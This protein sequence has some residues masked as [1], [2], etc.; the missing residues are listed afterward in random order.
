MDAVNIPNLRYKAFSFVKGI[1]KRNGNIECEVP[2][3]YKL[4]FICYVLG[5]IFL[6]YLA[7][8]STLLWLKWAFIELFILVTTLIVEHKVPDMITIFT[9]ILILF[10]LL[11]KSYLFLRKFAHLIKKRVKMLQLS[12]GIYVY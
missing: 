2:W 7:I 3:Q 8:Y 9:M 5:S 1:F 4:I 10:W 12:Q 11:I 6:I